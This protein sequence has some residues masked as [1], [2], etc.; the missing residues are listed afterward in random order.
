MA[1][2]IYIDS[3]EKA[4]QTVQ[5][6]LGLQ[7]NLLS[8][9]DGPTAVQYCAMLQPD[10]ILLNTALSAVDPVELT[11]R[12]K[13][14][15]PQTPILLIGGEIGD[16]PGDD[17]L[18]TPYSYNQLETFL[19]TWLEKTEQPARLIGTDSVSLA[20]VKMFQTQIAA[21]TQANQRL[22]TLNAVSALIGSSLDLE[23][24][25]D[26][27]LAQIQKTIT[28]DSATLLLL[29]DKMLVAAAARGFSEYQRGMNTYT[30][31]DHNS[32]WRVVSNKLPL[33]IN[34]VARS[35]YWEPRP[36]LSKIRA[37]L[38]VPLIYKD[39]VVGVL[40]LDRNSPT[41]FTEADARYVFTLAFQIAIAVE[42]AQLFEAWEKQTARLKLINEVSREINKFLN[43][44]NLFDAL[45][46]AVFEKLH[47]DWVSIWEI[48]DTRSTITLKTAYGDATSSQLPLDN[49]QQVIKHSAF[50]QAIHTGQPVLSNNLAQ[51]PNP[52]LTGHLNLQSALVMPVYV[53]SQIEVI[54]CVAR[55]DANT[56]D[57]QDLWTLS[58]L[59]R[60]A[61]IAVKNA[62]LYRGL[63]TYSDTLERT[64]AARTQR[65]QAIKK[66]SYVVS[67]G[68]DIDDL[69][70]L[71][72]QEI[73]QIFTGE[74]VD[75]I[76]VTIGLVQG[77]L[78]IL[79]GVLTLQ[80]APGALADQVISQVTPKILKDVSLQNLYNPT[81]GHKI[82]MI[83]SVL[84]TPLVTGGKTIGLIT[85]ESNQPNLFDDQDLEILETIAFQV[86]SAIEHARLMQKTR[87]IAIAEER[88]RLARDMHDGVAQNLA[89]LLLQV[90]RCLNM[91]DEGSNAET[92]LEKIGS[93]LKQ[94]IDELRRNIFDLRPVALEG[95]SLFDVL[96]N[97]VAEFGR[98]WHIKTHWYLR[99]NV[100]PIGPDI[101]RAIYRILQE[102]LSNAQQH[103]ECTE[104]SVTL[105]TKN[106][107]QIKLQVQDNGL[108]FN[109]DVPAKEQGVARRKG[110]GLTSMRERAENIGGQFTIT[111]APSE[112]TCITAVL[113]L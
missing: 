70:V 89:Y 108:V 106:K 31:N 112:G 23:Y 5:A 14:F 101:E 52:L 62:W 1:T 92:Q 10:L 27:I 105:H 85:V 81:Y 36:E 58:S 64:I 42:N 95:R 80:L 44:E 103:A 16:V 100:V 46:E 107:Q 82:Q 104:I 61:A 86:A 93:L 111:T 45:A 83:R 2:I 53:G 12:L 8:A 38:G 60:Q 35:R 51:E 7:H 33:I 4:H 87:D 76:Q 20:D 59:A 9:P 55:R 40:T 54:I 13:M 11:S 69:M 37:W 6:V 24:L 28:F 25:T 29:K 67:Q 47:Y 74:N 99:G 43:V 49:Y 94:N 68:L 109:E 48:D 26:E 77:L 90:D 30:K 84:A 15:M 71:V 56:F 73:Q 32:A 79:N 3:S 91:V 72:R 19:N 34:D 41:A 96:E 63:D 78:I 98:R 21:L 102:A 50:G 39:R 97:F 18:S 110:L 113:P 22:A 66:I 17:H 65:L 88:T 57:D 75:D